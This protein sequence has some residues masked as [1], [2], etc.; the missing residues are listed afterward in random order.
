MRHI[1]FLGV[2]EDSLRLWRSL[3]SK[4]KGTKDGAMKVLQH[5]L[6]LHLLRTLVDVRSSVTGML[7]KEETFE[8]SVTP[9]KD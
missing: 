9:D 1:R 8:F 2:A 7:A 6:E 4:K 5:R 3:E